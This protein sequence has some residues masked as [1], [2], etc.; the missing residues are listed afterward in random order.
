MIIWAW[1]EDLGGRYIIHG[2]LAPLSA[3]T[4]Q[5]LRARVSPCASCTA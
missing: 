3:L 1:Q 2:R 5:I 4:F